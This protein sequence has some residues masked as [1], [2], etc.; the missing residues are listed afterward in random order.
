MFPIFLETTSPKFRKKIILSCYKGNNINRDL[1]IS[2]SSFKFD[3]IRYI[4]RVKHTP[5][6]R[7]DFLIFGYSV[8]CFPPSSAPFY[9]NLDFP[10]WV[11]SILRVFTYL[12]S[13]LVL[14]RLLLPYF[15]GPSL[16]LSTERPEFSS[17][18]ADGDRAR[19]PLLL[20]AGK[21]FTGRGSPGGGENGRKTIVPLE[22]QTENSS[23]WATISP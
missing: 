4:F 2:I 21:I 12:D 6:K 19:G 9:S 15:P 11:F 16:L 10:T 8:V 13:N 17:K 22:S 7:G 23:S 3:N 14:L 18:R 20:L 1:E 5:P